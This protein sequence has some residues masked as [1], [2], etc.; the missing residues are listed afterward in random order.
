[1]RDAI[2]ASDLF[3]LEGLFANLYYLIA[4]PAFF[5]LSFVSTQLTITVGLGFLLSKFLK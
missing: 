2:G 3:F 5:L 1:V 4:F